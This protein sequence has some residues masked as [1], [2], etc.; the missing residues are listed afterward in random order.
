MCTYKDQIE[1]A[2]EHYK[3]WNFNVKQVYPMCPFVRKTLFL[4]VFLFYLKGTLA[5]VASEAGLVVDLAISSKLFNQV[6]SFLA[7][8][9]LLGSPCKCC[10]PQKKI[11]HTQKSI[12]SLTNNKTNNFGNFP[13]LITLST[14]NSFSCLF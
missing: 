10:H 8:F 5:V 4:L 13:S 6:H 9:A 12:K 7:C 3:T 2:N 14:S 1:E 11:F